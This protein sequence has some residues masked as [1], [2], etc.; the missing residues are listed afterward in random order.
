MLELINFDNWVEADGLPEGSGT[1]EKIWL[2][3][4][5]GTKCGLFKFPKT[6]NLPDGTQTISTEHV[7]EWLAYR[8]GELLGVLCAKVT[9]GYRNNRIGSLGTL[10]TEPCTDLVEGVNFI[11]EKFPCYDAKNMIDTQDNTYYCLRHILQSTQDYLPAQAW[12]EMLLF[13]FLIGNA[14]RHQS[15]W[16]LLKTSDQGYTRYIRCPLYDNG[17]SLCC[18][19][20]DNRLDLLFGKD[21]GPMRRLTDTGSFSM[22]RIDGSVK[23]R[24]THRQVAQYVL[25]QYPRIAIPI[26]SGFIKRLSQ[27]TLSAILSEL[28][29]S[30]FPP[31]RKELVTQY[32]EAKTA[33]LASLIS[34]EGGTM[35]G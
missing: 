11:R 17:S 15:N 29:D 20:P 4:P 35:Y 18:Y 25:H 30:I 3:S 24:P 14:D 22:I 1:S 16:A 23:K 27:G 5:S 28:P 7:S 34:Q 2:R 33:I 12:I 13:D 19:E 31:I 10:I 9:L 26:A 32:I 6:Q 8:L 21:P